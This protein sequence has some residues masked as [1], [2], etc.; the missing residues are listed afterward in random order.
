MKLKVSD[1][2]LEKAFIDPETLPR[3]VKPHKEVIKFVI[4]EGDSSDDSDSDDSSNSS[5]SS[6]AS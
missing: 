4:I 5:S 6:S 2:D 3:Q 1:E